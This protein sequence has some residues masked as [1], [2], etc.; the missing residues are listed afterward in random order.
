MLLLLL[1]TIILVSSPCLSEPDHHGRRGQKRKDGSDVGVL[2][3]EVV[4]EKHHMQEHLDEAGIKVDY[5]AMAPQEKMFYFFR[6]HDTDNSSTIDG[7][8]L[9]KGFLHDDFENH[10][11]GPEREGHHITPVTE[12]EM[13]QFTEQIDGVFKENDHNN[14]GH[15]DYIEFKSVMKLMM[16]SESS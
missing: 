8:E 3:T 15:I 10:L 14:D 1:L 13:R 2:D 11:H 4:Q 6:F 7:L 9:M 5:E 12:E 16:A